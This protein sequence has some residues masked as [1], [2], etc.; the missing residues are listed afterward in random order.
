MI[1]LYKWIYKGY[2][3]TMFED[4]EDDNIKCFHEYRELIVM[5]GAMPYPD[6]AFGK[7][8]LAHITP[9]DNTRG[10]FELFIDAIKAGA[11]PHGQTKT[12]TFG[13]KQ[14]CNWDKGSLIQWTYERFNMESKL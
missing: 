12:N 9:Y 14:A 13:T 8:E 4:V 7:R 3:L 5:V 6:M 11:D 1:E 10:T 2:Q